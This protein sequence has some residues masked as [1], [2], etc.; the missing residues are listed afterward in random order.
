MLLCTDGGDFVNVR[1]PMPYIPFPERGWVVAVVWI[2]HSS[3]NQMNV[4]TVGG[5]TSSGYS[6]VDGAASS[7]SAFAYQRILHSLRLLNRPEAG[8]VGEGALSKLLAGKPRFRLGNVGRH[9]C[10]CN[11]QKIA[12]LFA[13]VSCRCAKSGG[14]VAS[15]LERFCAAQGALKK[16]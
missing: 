16:G 10:T 13:H 14:D 6:D 1:D 15:P 11:V 12:R 7:G 9:G 3:V 5:F 8:E 4:Y 2:A